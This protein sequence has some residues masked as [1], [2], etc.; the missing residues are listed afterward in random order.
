M[1]GK[2]DKKEAADVDPFDQAF[3]QFSAPERTE[4]VESEE[5]PADDDAA[6]AAAAAA[7]GDDTPADDAEAKK[8]DDTDGTGDDAPGDDA[9]AAA[10]AA[11]EGKPPGK[12]EPAAAA[13]TDEGAGDDDVLK[14]L[15]KLIKDAPEEKPATKPAEAPK[16]VVPVYSEDEAKLLTDYEKD[17]P[18]VARAE[19]LKRRGEY[20]A[21]VDH[22]FKELSGPFAA[23][24]QQVQMLLERQQLNDIE[25]RVPDYNDK[26][27]DEVEGWIKTQ[28]GYLQAAYNHVIS[29]G[30]ANEIADL[31]SRYKTETGKAAAAPAAAPAK[32]PK[33]DTELPA[34]A[35]QA[36]AS[37]APV[38]SKRTV[39][40]QGE[41]LGDFESAFAKWSKDG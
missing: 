18:D 23:L 8:P 19:A 33:K 37:L 35:K 9:E 20:P 14:R 31:V 26:L 1:A 40:P 4:K 5:K 17:W 39:V 7:A 36:A 27:M 12:D 10:K 13:K 30:D 25:Q 15:S 34:D 22:I 2:D 28:P 24:T 11:T 6:K 16:P 38:S 41:D 32:A 21:I 3:A 29:N